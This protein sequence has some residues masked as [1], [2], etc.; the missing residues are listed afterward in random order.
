MNSLLKFIRRLV[1]IRQ[2]LVSRVLLLWPSLPVEEHS[3]LLLSENRPVVDPKFLERTPN[4]LREV[5]RSLAQQQDHCC[6]RRFDGKLTIDSKSGLLFADGRVIWRSTDLPMRRERSPYFLKHV[7]G[8]KQDADFEAV[9]SL[10]HIFDNNYFHFFNNIATKLP[11]FERAGVPNSVPLVISEILWRQPFFQDARA[12]GLFG[13]REIIVQGARQ[14]ISAR[15]VYT[16]TPYHYAET[17]ETLGRVLDRLGAPENPDGQRRIFL[18]RG[19]KANNRRFLRNE[20]E[21]I[22]LLDRHGIESVDPQELDLAGQMQLF[23]SARLIVSAHGA[24]LMNM[25]FRRKSPLDIVELFGPVVNPA[26]YVLARERGYGYHGL[27]NRGAKNSRWTATSEVDIEAVDRILTVVGRD[28][29]E[30]A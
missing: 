9:A 16:A 20:A 19:E 6:V 12:M 24:G 15:T 2:R 8:R 5:Y 10:R 29:A 22:R 26:C 4:F 27:M 13:D 3:E 30:D 14:V 25:I 23:G 17:V 28:I 7:V 18:R 21:L 11:L 1:R